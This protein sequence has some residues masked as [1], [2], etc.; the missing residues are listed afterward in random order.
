MKEANP[1]ALVAS[2]EVDGP[3]NLKWLLEEEEKEGPITDILTIHVYGS[4]VFEPEKY[5]I[6]PIFE[7][8]GPPDQSAGYGYILRKFGKGRPLWLSE[9]N[10]G[11][12]I[13]DQKR[14]WNEIEKR[15]WVEKVFIF[16]NGEDWLTP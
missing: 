8:L 13:E 10:N 2:T 4:D 12:S 14:F 3:L 9:T 5:K 1:A 16:R 11:T 7:L 15:P 6:D